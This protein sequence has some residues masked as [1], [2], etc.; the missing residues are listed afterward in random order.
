MRRERNNRRGAGKVRGQMEV[1][2]VPL[3]KLKPD[4]RNARGH[5]RR[6]I[7]AIKDSLES[8][9]QH[10]PF[11]VQK[12]TGKVIVGNGMLA[13][14][15]ELGWTEGAAYYVDDSEA[16]SVKRALADNRTG[17]LAEWN[18]EAL[19]DIMTEFDGEDM[20]GWTDEERAALMNGGEEELPKEQ[21]FR[22]VF[23]ILIECDSEAQQE[24]LYNEFIER[25]LKCRVQSF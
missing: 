7:E 22:E 10:R 11:V 13:A 23:S 16:E 6:N 4:K 25:G 14:M 15:K 19:A 12:S 24:E 2:I 9:G 17:E 5:N 1:V 18:I 8:F 21:P 20:I 3:S